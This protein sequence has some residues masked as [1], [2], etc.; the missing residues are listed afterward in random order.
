M[1]AS[2]GNGKGNECFSYSLICEGNGRMQYSM[3]KQN[4]REVGYALG[5]V[6]R[7][8]LSQNATV[9]MLRF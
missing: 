7:F 8:Q 1:V 2:M 6:F 5:E 9:A 3:Y 4:W